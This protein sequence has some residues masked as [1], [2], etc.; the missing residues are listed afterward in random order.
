MA[1]TFEQSYAE[2][3]RQSELDALSRDPAKL[4]AAKSAYEK[5]LGGSSVTSVAPVAT[6]TVADSGRLYGGWYDNPETGK[7]QRYWGE[8]VW[9]N[10][11]E[12]GLPKEESQVTSFL[13]NYQNS[14]LDKGAPEIRNMLTGGIEKP[15]PLNREQAFTDLRAEYG[16]ADL[17][18]SLNDLKAQEEEIVAAFRQQ[19]TAERDKPVATNVISGR[20]GKE[21]RDAS[22]R[23]DY[24]GR[25]KSRV[26]DELNTKYSIIGQI[27]QFKGEDYQD[28]VQSY[29]SAFN[30]NL[31]IYKLISDEKTAAETSARANLQIYMNAITAGNMDFNSLGADQKVMIN[32]LEAQ[33]GLP[34]GFVSSLKLDPKANILFTSSNDGVTQVGIKNPD[35]TISVQNYGTKNSG[36]KQTEAEFAR[37]AQKE[38]ATFL[39]SKANSY[40]HVSGKVYQ[41]VRNK[42]VEETGSTPDEFDTAFRAY[43]DP[44]NLGSYGLT[45]SEEDR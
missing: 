38:V 5:G 22:E 11:E 30:Q 6:G 12:P 23:L 43:R 13:N 35:G 16:V 9:T 39:S 29:E 41:Q 3:G 21:E 45:R 36:G 27:M 31:Q 7:N 8:G 4:S 28:A 33:S 2:T 42:W 26:V 19:R 32:K 18:T 34:V 17:E 1:K 40:G 25:Q 14:I 20:I 24:L 44:Y 10:G 15:A 37:T